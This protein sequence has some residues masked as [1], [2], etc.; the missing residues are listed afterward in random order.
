[1]CDECSE[2]NKIW[3]RPRVTG[4]LASG[5]VAGEGPL[6]T[7]QTPPIPNFRAVPRN[8][9]FVLAD[10]ETETELGPEFMTP[11]PTF[12]LLFHTTFFLSVD[13]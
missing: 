13:K 7:C 12:L 1:M 5:R 6:S 3:M 8:S 11:T 9:L 4:R 10:E 2:E